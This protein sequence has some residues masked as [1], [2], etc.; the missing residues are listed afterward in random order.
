M[1]GI[2]YTYIYHR[3]QCYSEIHRP[4]GI[5]INQPYHKTVSA[6]VFPQKYIA[7]APQ[8]ILLAWSMNWF[9]WQCYYIFGFKEIKYDYDMIYEYDNLFKLP[10][11]TVF[12]E[13]SNHVFIENIQET[14][15]KFVGKKKWTLPIN[16]LLALLLQEKSQAKGPGNCESDLHNPGKMFRRCFSPFSQFSHSLRMSGV[17][18]F[19]LSI[20]M[21]NGHY[22]VGHAVCQN[23]A[24]EYL[25]YLENGLWIDETYC[26]M[27]CVETTRSSVCSIQLTPLMCSIN[28]EERE[29][30][31]HHDL[32]LFR[33]L[34]YWTTCHY[35]KKK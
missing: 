11:C 26:T 34:M 24:K 8:P 17:N 31:S 16:H 12:C 9:P 25:G 6:S 3:V 7:R 21:S 2:V 5:P 28:S 30:G 33:C 10:K 32:C 27:K 18:V 1:L 22:T 15:K 20:S 13:K 35:Y 14:F 29:L 19:F 23:F 4:P